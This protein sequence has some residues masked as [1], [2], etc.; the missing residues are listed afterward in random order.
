MC[1]YIYT[2]IYIYIYISYWY[3]RIRMHTL[4]RAYVG[5]YVCRTRDAR[6]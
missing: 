1:V 4:A 6:A 5:A 2:Y 3:A